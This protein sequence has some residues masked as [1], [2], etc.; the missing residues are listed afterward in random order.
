MKH[1]SLIFILLFLS[2]IFSCSKKG[3][4]VSQKSDVTEVITKLFTSCELEDMELLSSI[5]AHDE[6]IV[7][8]GISLAEHH[9]GWEEWK[10]SLMEQ[11]AAIDETKIIST[12]LAVFISETGEV[13]WFSDISNWKFKIND[14]S[15]KLNNVRITGVLEKR[16][17]QWKIVQV[18]ASAPQGQ[19][20]AYEYFNPKYKNEIY[21]I[22]FIKL[23]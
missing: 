2:V 16:K 22:D 7:C 13:A 17:G 14:N 19:I 8:F 15:M 6:D 23:F 4:V 11:W 1:V 9:V 18:H 10:T 21:I 20:T 3:N 12:D 5:V